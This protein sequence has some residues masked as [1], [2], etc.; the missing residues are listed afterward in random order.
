MLYGTILGLIKHQL[1]IMEEGEETNIGIGNISRG[2]CFKGLAYKLTS[3]PH[4]IGIELRITCKANTRLS[5]ATSS[6]QSLYKANIKQNP[7]LLIGTLCHL[8]IKFSSQA[9]WSRL[10]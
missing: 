6:R 8:V 1:R 5:E 7:G 10:I 9:M 2:M 4:Q 3:I